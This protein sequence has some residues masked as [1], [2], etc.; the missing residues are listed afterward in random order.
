MNQ[1]VN[2]YQP[3]AA[4]TS[5]AYEVPEEFINAGR[6][7]RLGTYVVD[8]FGF[9]FVVFFVVL[10]MVVAGGEDMLQAIEGPLQY[11]VSFGTM[12]GYYL[13]FEGLWGRTP[14]KFACG[15]MVIAE[16]GAKPSFGQVLGRTFARFIPFEPF[17]LLFSG[18]RV[19]WHDSL[20][21]T[22]VVLAPG[23]G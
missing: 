5:L 15:T 14:G 11:V 12:V 6:W 8:Y 1:P 7:R 17:S 13:L 9:L 4:D 21:R 22:R 3:P 20:P 19:G 10:A 23:R 2:P 18:E 16:D